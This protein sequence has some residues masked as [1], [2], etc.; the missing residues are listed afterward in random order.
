[1]SLPDGPF[2]FVS[3]SNKDAGF[4]HA[5]IKRLERQGYKVWYDQ[6]KLQPARFWAEEI[7]A[8]ITA[9]ACFVVFI[10]EDSVA[11]N[12]VCDEI[13]QALSE[14]K[15][16]IGVY[17]DNV[18]L[19][20][21]LQHLVRRRQTLDR[22]SMHQSAYEGPLKN[23]LSE[24]VPI[25]L[26]PPPAQFSGVA[27]ILS[28]SDPPPPDILPRLVCFGLVGSGGISLFLAVVAVITPNMISAKSPDDLLNNRV[29]GLIGGIMLAIIGLGLS[30]AAVA[31]FRAY[32]WRRE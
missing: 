7:R 9:C 15:P 29:L 8:A 14:N 6:G 2:V 3:Y 1:M 30:G 12:H 10:T 4:V 23:A 25:T 11:S 24:Y 20:A 22:H 28:A 27:P 5:E 31:V 19:P 21:G 32:L 13:D 17:W 18:E 26:T 16:F